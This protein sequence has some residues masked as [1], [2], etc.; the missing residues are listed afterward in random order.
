MVSIAAMRACAACGACGVL[1]TAWYATQPAPRASRASRA[2]RPTHTVVV[3]PPSY[4]K[5]VPYVAVGVGLLYFGLRSP[6][7]TAHQFKTTCGALRSQVSTVSAALD[8]VR[9]LVLQRFGVVESRLDDIE[10]TLLTKTAEI[11]R[12]VA[13]VETMLARM[14]GQ[15]STIETQTASSSSGVK[16]L[17][18][19]VARSLDNTLSDKVAVAKRLYGMV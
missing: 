12:D 9:S 4:G 6:Y 17:C 3:H 18:D 19:V 5:Y 14:G 13:H 11:K 15:V 1:G 7:V 16:M 8:K 2:S 10:R